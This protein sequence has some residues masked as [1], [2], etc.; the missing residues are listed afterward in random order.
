M[1]TSFK[2]SSLTSE[3]GTRATCGPIDALGSGHPDPRIQDEAKRDAM[4]L[5]RDIEGHSREEADR[6]AR[7]IVA[8]AMQRVALG[9]DLETPSPL[10]LPTTR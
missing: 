6:R 1:R 10:H 8:I 9:G 4:V 2:R 5:V 7:K 3:D